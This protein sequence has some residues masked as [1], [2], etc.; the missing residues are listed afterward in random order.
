M[1][2]PRKGYRIGLTR[3]YRSEVGKPGYVVNGLSARCRQEGGDAVWVLRRC[4]DRKEAQTYEQLYLARYGLP[5][6][7]FRA[8]PYSELDQDAIDLVFRNV[9]TCERAEQLAREL[10]IDL[11][12]PHYTPVAAKGYVTLVYLASRRNRQHCSHR[13]HFET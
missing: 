6:L 5:G 10:G 7:C 3:G 12:A 11:R 4:S 1:R 9:P 2:H 8:G 13:I